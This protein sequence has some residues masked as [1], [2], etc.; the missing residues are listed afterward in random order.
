MTLVAGLLVLAGLLFGVF[1]VRRSL[2]RPALPVLAEA[3]LHHPTSFDSRTSAVR[4]LRS[5][6]DL[7][8]AL[9]RANASATLV[10]AARAS[11]RYA[12][13]PRSRASGG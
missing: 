7:T 9:E 11:R 4:V 10:A 12:P 6:D 1:F 3:R 5:S 2:R 13:P 8:S